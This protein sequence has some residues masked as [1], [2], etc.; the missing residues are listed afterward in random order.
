MT[1]TQTALETLLDTTYDSVEGYRKA[2]SLA[3]SPEL[4]Q[5]LD[6]QAARRQKSLEMLNAEL[7]RQGGT[8]VTKGT[9]TG[10]L[11]RMWVDITAMFEN[12]DEAAVSRVEE[13]ED[14]LA[15]KIDEA[16]EHADLD[17]QTRSVIEQVRAEVRE[18]ERLADQLEAQYD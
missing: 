13:G 7:V 11:H 4:K 15:G 16:L 6:G 12:G 14:Y 8:L 5:A 18:G 10:S 17:P 1:V 3:K 9:M 2:A